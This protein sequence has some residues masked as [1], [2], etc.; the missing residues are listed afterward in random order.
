MVILHCIGVSAGTAPNMIMPRIFLMP[1]TLDELFADMLAIF[2]RRHP[3][4]MDYI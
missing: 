1:Q 4:T 3:L 2:H